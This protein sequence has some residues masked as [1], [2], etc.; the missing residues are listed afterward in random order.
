MKNISKKLEFVIIA[1][2]VV[3]NFLV[4]LVSDFHSG[5][6]GDELLHIEAGRHLAAGYMDFPTV[7]AVLAFLQNLFQSDSLF[8]NHLFV[9]LASALIFIFAGLITIELGGKSL[10]VLAILSCFFFSPGISASHSIFLPVLFEQL[11]WVICIYYLVKYCNNHFPKYLILTGIFAAIGFL[12][13]YSTTFLIAGI[14]I[15]VYIFQRDLLK[16]RFLWLGLMLFLLIILPNLFW[17]F[18]NGFPVFH[19]FT[20]LYKTQL[21][22]TTILQELKSLILLL[23]PL[24]SV[25]WV[26]GLLITPFLIK[27]KKY[28]LASFSL[29]FAFF[30]LIIAK[31]KSYYYFP[32]ILGVLPFSA[33]LAESFLQKRKW[34]LFSYLSLIFISGTYLLP[35]GIN[36]LPLKTY[37]KIY[38]PEKNQSDK[39]PL[40]FENFYSAENWNHILNKVSATYQNLP[41]TEQKNCLIWGRHYS[42]AGGINLMGKEYGLPLAFSFHSSFYQWVPDFQ[43]DITVII[44]SDLSWDREHW[45][46]YFDEVETVCDI[47]NRFASNKEWSVQHIFLCRKLKFNSD[48]LKQK[49]SNEIF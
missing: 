10:A 18:K 12:T 45:L 31:G 5:F 9:Y 4:H 35:N 25:L 28:K 26:C 17:Q 30:L 21:N 1:S 14:V 48:E 27:L 23:N 2:F 38:Y 49:F 7:I 46:R 36:I 13:K 43:K 42:Q 40:P 16:N 20:E 33:V 47:Q 44:I 15:S 6:H 29:F 37:I 3:A 22:K 34:I 32:V 41:E 39:I 11:F 8:V 24:T 19:H